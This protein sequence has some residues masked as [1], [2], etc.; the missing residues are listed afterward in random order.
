METKKG[1]LFKTEYQ[2]MQSLVVRT[3]HSSS[4]AFLSPNINR[5]AYIC[6]AY[7]KGSKIC[8]LFSSFLCLINNIFWRLA[9]SGTLISNGL[10]FHCANIAVL[11]HPRL[12][13]WMI[14]NIYYYENI[15]PNKI[16]KI[17]FYLVIC[18]YLCFVD[19]I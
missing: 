16:L 6:V 12:I 10:G 7:S 14:L 9:H 4:Q 5:Y 2:H 8:I 17:F 18:P 13:T 11:N 1:K 19:H 15:A 3:Q